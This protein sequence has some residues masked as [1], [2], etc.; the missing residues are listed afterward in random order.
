MPCVIG[1]HAVAVYGVDVMIDEHAHPFLLEFS[2]SPDT[3]TK[4][5]LYP[6]LWNDVFT[7]LFTDT[8]SLNCTRI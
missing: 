6:T 4:A 2:F 5:A 8:P 7:T 3:T 1:V